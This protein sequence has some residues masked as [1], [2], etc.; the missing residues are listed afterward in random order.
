[1]ATGVTVIRLFEHQTTGCGKISVTVLVW[2]PS[3]LASSIPK[4]GL[5][6]CSLK[7]DQVMNESVPNVHSFFTSQI[8]LISGVT[9]KDRWI[10]GVSLPTPVSHPHLDG[11]SLH[12][13]GHT[14]TSKTFNTFMHNLVNFKET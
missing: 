8:C 4:W 13:L 12:T 11:W 2:D 7:T 6:F 9:I 3:P 10:T 1:L 5:P 14:G